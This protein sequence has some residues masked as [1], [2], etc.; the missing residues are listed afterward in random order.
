MPVRAFIN[1][2]RQA[3]A[4]R[5]LAAGGQREAAVAIGAFD[6]A[7]LAHLWGYLVE[8]DFR[9]SNRSALGVTDTILTD[10]ALRG[11]GGKR[12]TYRRT[13]EGAKA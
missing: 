9:Y 12:L 2:R 8:F 4:L 1:P 13:G 3:F 11:I 6:E 5:P 7:G 10:E